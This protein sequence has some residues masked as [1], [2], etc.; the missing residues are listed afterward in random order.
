MKDTLPKLFLENVEKYPDYAAQFTKDSE[1]V[2]QPTSY[3]ELQTEVYQF[4][5]GLKDIGISKGDHVG[6]ISENRKEWLISDLALMS[7]GA[8][9]VPRGC[10]STAQELRY[11]LD[12]SECRVCCVENTT[13]MAK[14]LTE[15]SSIPKLECFIVL[16]SESTSDTETGGTKVLNFSEVMEKGKEYLKSHPGEIEAEIEKGGPNDLATIIFTSGTTGEPKGVMLSHRNFLHQ[17]EQVPNLLSVGP[18]DKW[19]SVLPIWHSFERIMT[20]VAVGWASSLAYSKPIRKII[21]DD[22]GAI[23]PTWMASVPRIWES[24]QDGIY[25]SIKAD[26]GIK[27]ALFLFFVGI[28]KIHSKASNLVKGLVP[29]YRKR[30]RIL[31]IIA[32]IIP[33]ILLYPLR[34]LGNILVFSKIHKRLGGKFVAGVS[35]GGGLPAAVDTFFQA[36]GILLIEGYGM[37]ETAPVLS[38]RRQSHPVP[39]TIG[40]IFPGTEFKIIDDRGGILP[41]GE[42]GVLHVRGPQVMLGYYNKPELTAEII[43]SEG[44][45][46]TG[47]LAMQT[48]KGEIKIMGRAK[49]TIVL[50]GGENI[51]P[52]P[53][54]EKIKESPYINTAVVLGQDKKYIAALV[55][56][57]MDLIVE[58]AKEH[59]VVYSEESDLLETPEVLDLIKSEINEYV[60]AKTGFKVFERIS[61]FK[62]LGTE[63]EVGKELSGKQEVKRHAVNDMYKKEIAGLFS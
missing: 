20:Y 6:L 15:K 41:P 8:A 58:F 50:L 5:S 32:G 3:S 21:A 10:D 40:P 33:Y 48:W 54:E 46:N 35:G 51:E 47:D 62:L 7:I 22:M 12:F 25:R 52:N 36:A 42:K 60:S 2:F 9:D 38:L 13:Q 19:L 30:S 17:I 63:F 16:D 1:G 26:G 55:V 37:T 39:G 59:G 49:D 11:I 27:K 61:K 18:G 45:L 57:Q 43:D 14:I 4:A 31:D 56:G 53:I 28:G 24:L 23:Q 29:Q 34:A 44:W